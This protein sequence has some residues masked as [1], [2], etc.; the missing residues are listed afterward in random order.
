MPDP[1]MPKSTDSGTPS[2]ADT[3]SIR[4]ETPRRLILRGRDG[5]TMTL[6]PLERTCPLLLSK[7]EKFDFEHLQGQ[8]FV[9]VLVTERMDAWE[10]VAPLLPFVGVG[11]YFGGAW[12]NKHLPSW[13]MW[14]WGFGAVLLS[15]VILAIYWAYKNSRKRLMRG[16]TQASA[17]VL[18]LTIGIGAP[19]TAIYFFGSGRDLLNNQ[20]FAQAS[21]L[22]L[23]GRL[24]QLSMISVASL[25]PGLLYF[26]FDRQSLA[27]M[28][29]LFERAVF[30]LD[31]SLQTLTDVRAKYGRQME[32]VYGPDDSR[33]VN[34]RLIP[35]TRVP[36]LLG[37]LVL[38]LGWLVTLGPVGNAPPM[39]EPKDLLLLLTPLRGAISFAFLGAYFFSLGDILR[40]YVRGDLKPKAYT[41]TVVR[42]IFVVILAWVIDRILPPAI[43][44]AG[45]AI[46]KP[47]GLKLALLFLVGYF[48]DT[49]LTFIREVLRPKF[50]KLLKAPKEEESPLTDLDG[51][52]IYDRSRLLDEGLTNVESL[53]HHDFIDLMMETRVPVP[54]LID[55]VDQA[56]LYLHVR[57]AAKDRESSSG[58]RARLLTYG[59]RTAT[60]L[61]AACEA[62]AARGTLA[63]LLQTLS[64]QPAGDKVNRVQVIIDAL[65]DDEWLSC[66]RH[67][68]SYPGPQ[69][70]T[71]D[72]PSPPPPLQP[73]LIQ[74]AAA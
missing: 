25:L 15:L 28:R 41:S 43:T 10:R 45:E 57:D 34:G 49:G 4:N 9:R 13:K 56:I 37:T 31:P 46:A 26:L 52:D 14:Y 68:R 11:Y 65:M 51:I 50:V 3:A 1:R 71:C 20:A 59:I 64:G 32:E 6:A 72:I 70:E 29:G 67:W 39:R 53:A 12:I 18:M 61:L 8:N 44:N 21:P 17:C 23:L 48:P 40:R 27:T 33:F 42:A 24:L 47:E 16:L 5:A 2:M 62:A 35:G 30:R 66:V 22:L 55:W 7:V 58:L 69:D 38:T 54:R 74:Q 73:A 60:D 19:A 63:D 36:V